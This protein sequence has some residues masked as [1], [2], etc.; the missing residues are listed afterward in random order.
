MTNYLFISVDREDASQ[1]TTSH[2]RSNLTPDLAFRTAF[3]EHLGEDE[4][5]E[6]Y[7]EEVVKGDVVVG[8]EMVTYDE[9][10]VTF[11]LIPLK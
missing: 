7:Y 10:F 9:E 11:L 1:S 3:L 4:G 6:D 8:R 2:F 5:A